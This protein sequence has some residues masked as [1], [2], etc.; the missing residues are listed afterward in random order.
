M[1]PRRFD[2]RR[3]AQRGVDAARRAVG[4]KLRGAALYG[5]AV[6]GEFHPGHSDVNVAFVFS[7]LGTAE[8]SALN[9][10][11]PVWRRSRVVRPLLL[12]E[13][14]LR[15]SLDSYP[16]EYLL[17][18]E[19]HEAIFGVDYFGPVVIDREELRLEVERVLRAQEL[20]LGLSYVA[21]AGT[22]GG[23]R[24]WALQALNAIAASASGL[25]YLSGRPV[26]R[27][28]RDLAEH[29][30]AAFGVDAAAFTRLLTLRET[31]R[32]RVAAVALLDSALTIL[33]QLLESAER[34][35]AP[36]QNA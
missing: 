12:S 35:S 6:S 29:C 11:Y 18:R 33:N 23:A 8:L 9:R 4:E 24:L 27:R 15:R 25:L 21:L 22:R 20:G 14:S 2:A 26:P 5:S 1:W 19:G 30:A 32:D 36:P 3:A 7:A 17:I 10:A 28:K 31:K 13:E 34:I 16:L